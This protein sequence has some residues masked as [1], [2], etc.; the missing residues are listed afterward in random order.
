[1]LN[2]FWHFSDA[3]GNACINNWVAAYNPNAASD[4]QNYDW[5]RFD[6]FG[7]M[8]TGWFMD[9]DGSW[10]YLNPVSDGTLGKMLTGW[11]WIADE[12]G[13]QRCYYLNPNSDG[14]RGKM[15]TN[16]VVDGY[17]IDA[18]GWWTVDGI[19]QVE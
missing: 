16:T 12:T 10:Y 15:L 9:S 18:N 8:L 5:F 19:V 6:P 11:V 4:Q 2:G 1:M 13:V 14:Y 17:T 3:S 7:N